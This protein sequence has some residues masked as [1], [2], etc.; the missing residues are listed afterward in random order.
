MG[1]QGSQGAEELVS[2]RRQLPLGCGGQVTKYNQKAAVMGSIKEQEDVGR[3][4]ETGLFHRWLFLVME[5]PGVSRDV[6]S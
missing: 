5:V 4:V 1:G 6:G 3:E 2:G